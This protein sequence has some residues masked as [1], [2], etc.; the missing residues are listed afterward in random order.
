VRP[1]EAT[2]IF[3][4]LWRHGGTYLDMKM[5]VASAGLTLFYAVL[6]YRELIRQ[7]EGD[8]MKLRWWFSYGQPLRNLSGAGASQIK[9]VMVLGRRDVVVLLG[10]VLAYFEQLPVVALYMLIISLVRAA[11]ALGQLLTPDWRIRPPG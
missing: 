11:A 10:I 8:V 3:M 7:G 1:A 5:A 9:G 2:A 6:A 4:S